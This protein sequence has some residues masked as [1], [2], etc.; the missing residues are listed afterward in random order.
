M[1][2]ANA[3]MAPTTTWIN[4]A[5]TPMA[6]TNEGFDKAVLTPATDRLLFVIKTKGP[7]STASLARELDMTAEAARQQVQ[8]LVGANL[9]EGQ[10]EAPT[11]AGRPRQLWRLTEAGNTRY[12]DTHAQLSVQLIGAV[13]EVFGENGLDELIARRETKMRAD[14]LDAC[15]GKSL[16][17][18]LKQ[19]AALRSDEGYMARVERDGKDWLLIEQHCPICAAAQIC[20]GFC[21]TELELFRAVVGTGATVTREKHLLSGGGRC[22]YRIA[23][24]TA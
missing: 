14:Y 12:P 4:T 6:R 22:V 5:A 24:A 13:R 7:I 11:G 23:S 17:Q 15:D 16:G 20:Q 3:S 2:R 19:L 9:I 1:Y 10:M 18:R 21:R 8:K